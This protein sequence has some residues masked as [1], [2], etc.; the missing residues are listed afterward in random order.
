MVDITSTCTFIVDVSSQIKTISITT[1]AGAA[2][3]DTIDLGSD[4]A[5]GRGAKIRV[6]KNSVIQDDLGAA[7]VATWVPGTG[8][9]TL[10]TVTTGIHD[11]IVWGLG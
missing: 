3:G 9:I 1:P 4:V 11:L 7:K 5:D 8:I 6:I 2:T 10:G